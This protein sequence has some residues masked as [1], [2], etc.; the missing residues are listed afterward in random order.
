MKCPFCKIILSHEDENIIG[1]NEI[2]KSQRCNLCTYIIKY[3][4]SFKYL[5][6]WWK[7]EIVDID[8]YTIS[9]YHHHNHTWIHNNLTGKN[10]YMDTMIDINK[11]SLNKIK[12][13]ILFS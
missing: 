2:E 1:D 3:G 6:G 9:I 13:Y 5:N 11:L 7:T 8:S 12:N 10:F 4:R